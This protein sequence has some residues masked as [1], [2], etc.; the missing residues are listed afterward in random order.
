MAQVPVSTRAHVPIRAGP[1]VREMRLAQGGGAEWHRS[2]APGRAGGGRRPCHRARDG[3]AGRQ[4]AH[5]GR[6]RARALRNLRGQSGTTVTPGG[7]SPGTARR[8]RRPRSRT[9]VVGRPARPGG[10]R[11]TPDAAND[12]RGSPSGISPATGRIATAASRLTTCPGATGGLI[13]S[14]GLGR[15]GGPAGPRSSRGRLRSSASWH[16]P[17][18]PVPRRGPQLMWLGSLASTSAA[19]RTAGGAAAEPLR[20]R[21]RIRSAS[22]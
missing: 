13:G 21:P 19:S 8:R 6:E 18:S 12:N 3:E 16:R 1:R 20:R 9:G 22:T 14:A 10:A 7:T 4:M 2:R 15:P 11:L 17:P 5:R